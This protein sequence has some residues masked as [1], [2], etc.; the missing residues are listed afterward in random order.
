MR[1]SLLNLIWA[2]GSLFMFGTSLQA[3]SPLTVYAQGGLI[4][5]TPLG[6]IS[7]VPEGATGK[8]GVGAN[9]GLELKI[10]LSRRMSL[11]TG[12]L[13]AHKSNEFETPV[14][15]KYNLS[16]GIL[17]IK[18]PFPINAK[19]K[20][21]ATGEFSNQYLDFPIYVGLQTGRRT[22]LSFGYQYSQLLQGR[23]NGEADVKALLLNFR[24]QEFDE[25]HLISEEDHAALAG[26]HYQIADHL[27]MRLR[28]AY[29]LKGIF[30]EAPEGMDNMRN[31]Y[32]GLMLAYGFRP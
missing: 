27:E 32:M 23:L 16:D 17:G 8:L 2:L 5:G 31:L 12:I 25:S 10:N 4:I 21:T 14:S 24:D 29:G 26:V 19:Y 13:F 15:G 20:G 9:A 22:V 7:S 11:N 1:L 30:T 6:N 28:F 3:Q 18:L